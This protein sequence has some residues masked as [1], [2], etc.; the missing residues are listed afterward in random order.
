MGNSENDYHNFVEKSG[1]DCI[2]VGRTA[3]IIEIALSICAHRL[4]PTFEKLFTGVNVWHRVQ[5]IGTGCKQLMK[6]TPGDICFSF[7]Y[8]LSWS[9]P[10]PEI[11]E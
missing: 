4:P 8:H 2:K 7:T 6:L 10:D 9:C 1:V 5:K 3:Q 11:L